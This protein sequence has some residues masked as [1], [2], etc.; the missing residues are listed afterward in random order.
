MKPIG[1]FRR[2]RSSIREIKESITHRSNTQ[3]W[4]PDLPRARQ[5]QWWYRLGRLMVLILGISWCGPPA[6][7]FKLFLRN[8]C[9]PVTSAGLKENKTVF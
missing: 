5:R 4:R 9:I 2:F 3:R 1:Y 7:A 6:Q 8:N